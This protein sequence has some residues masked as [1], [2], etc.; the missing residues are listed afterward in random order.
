MLEIAN[1]KVFKIMTLLDDLVLIYSF[2]TITLRPVHSI[3]FV[4][5]VFSANIW[6]V[7]SSITIAKYKSKVIKSNPELSPTELQTMLTISFKLVYF[8]LNSS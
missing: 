5:H 7:K 1:K 4:K 3:W 8:I 6:F 2:K